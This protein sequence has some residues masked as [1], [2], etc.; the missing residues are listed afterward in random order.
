MSTQTNTCAVTIAEP[1]RRVDVVVSTETPIR[2]L[3]PTFVEL[4]VDAPP[5]VDGPQPVWGIAPPGKQP[6]APESTLAESGIV[7]GAVLSLVQ[8]RS[9]AHAPPAPREVHRAEIEPGR[10]TPRER[11]ARALPERLRWDDRTWLATKAFFGN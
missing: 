7:D 9:V 10:G 2:L 8:V 6:L 3:I 4:S 5:P 11:T 1:D